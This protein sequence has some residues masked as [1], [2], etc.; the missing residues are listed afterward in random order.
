MFMLMVAS[1][2]RSIERMSETGPSFEAL[3]RPYRSLGRE[4]YRVLL[5]VVVAANSIGAVVMIWLGAWP[6]LGFLGL[7][8]LA[9]IIAFRLSYAQAAAFERITIGNGDLVIER[10]DA[11]G[12]R[13]E[14]RFAS[15]WVS[16]LFDGD[17][18][19]GTVTLRSHG[20]SL[21]IGEFLV[22]FERKSFADALKRALHTAKDLPA[23]A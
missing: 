2:L 23:P 11:K 7:D 21:E 10:V 5:R 17:D 15:Y 4:G 16:V 12:R 22:P 18:E 1:R 19:A 3:I 20:R 8:V 13:R 9:I 6:V 14:W